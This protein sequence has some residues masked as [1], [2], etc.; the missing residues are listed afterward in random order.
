MNS[1]CN[2]DDSLIHISPKMRK[3]MS[4]NSTIVQS[5]PVSDHPFEKFIE[6]PNNELIREMTDVS[7]L[8]NTDLK[9][10]VQIN[11]SGVHEKVIEPISYNIYMKNGKVFKWVSRIL[12]KTK[13]YFIDK[14]L[15][16]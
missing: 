16:I 14:S 3:M 6:I 5:Q 1:I 15:G 4:N 12:R 7:T 8:P 10:V 2:H 13:F 9:G 11:K